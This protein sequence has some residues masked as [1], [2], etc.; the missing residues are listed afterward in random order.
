MTDVVALG[1][2]MGVFRAAGPFR[3]GGTGELTVS[4][5]DASPSLL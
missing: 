2:T 4:K 5:G 1:E 3:L